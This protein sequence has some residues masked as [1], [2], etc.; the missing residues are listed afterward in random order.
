MID[1]DICEL[2]DIDENLICEDVRKLINDYYRYCD[3]L[4]DFNIIDGE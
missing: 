1:V 4:I 2:I 3:S